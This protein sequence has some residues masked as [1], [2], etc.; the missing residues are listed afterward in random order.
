MGK[1]TAITT[2]ELDDNAAKLLIGSRLRGKA[3]A[4]FHSKPELL[5][6]TVEEILQQMRAI[7]D[8][9]PSRVDARK[10]FEERVWQPT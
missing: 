2:Y 9:R 4:W 10:Q 8:Y 6:M 5:S 3:Q 1:T 7:Y